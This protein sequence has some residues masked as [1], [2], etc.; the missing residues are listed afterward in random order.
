MPY[1][2]KMC[3]TYAACSAV[4]PLVTGCA[5]IARLQ[6]HGGLRRSWTT[7]P[8]EET[9]GRWASTGLLRGVQELTCDIA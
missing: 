8:M 6:R 2:R 4:M 9:P 3:G 5:R 1:A 7:E